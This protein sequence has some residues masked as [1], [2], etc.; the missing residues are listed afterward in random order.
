MPVRPEPATKPVDERA[1]KDLLRGGVLAAGAAA[2]LFSADRIFGAVLGRARAGALLA[3]LLAATPEAAGVATQIQAV[4]SDPAPG[5]VSPGAIWYNAATG[6]VRWWDSISGV[7]RS[8]KILAVSDPLTPSAG[9]SVVL[10]DAGSSA[11][12][13]GQFD[14]PL[15]SVY[16][17]AATQYI[18][19][20]GA[21]KSATPAADVFGSTGG[22]WMFIQLAAVGGQ[23]NGLQILQVG[24]E[25][26]VVL[27]TDTFNDLIIDP[28]GAF[29]QLAVGAGFAVNSK[30]SPVGVARTYG[31]IPTAGGGL[32]AIRAR[33]W[34]AGLSAAQATF[35]TYTPAADT[36]FEANLFVDGTLLT[37]G[38]VT[39]T[40]S[41]KHANGTTTRTK[42][43]QFDL[44]GGTFATSVGFGTWGAAVTVRGRAKGSHSITIAI[45][46]S[47]IAGTFDA[48]GD[49]QETEPA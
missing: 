26:V 47:G 35:V 43:V 11:N 45:A 29:A 39:A 41:W 16:N 24:A 32:P 25:G 40:V 30:T 13:A 9:T 31:G 48:G 10:V 27:S 14:A 5:T 28:A 2:A 49:I 19:T 38:S 21:W 36:Q 4:T 37:A 6:D 42:T 17:P 22:L 12:G 3:P 34:A 8:T 23:H 7:I 33:N 1:R 46:V 15:L 20:I 18:P 44:A